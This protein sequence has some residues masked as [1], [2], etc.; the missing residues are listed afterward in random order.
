MTVSI[1]HLGCKG[2]FIGRQHCQWSRHTVV[3]D[4]FVISTLGMLQWPNREPDKFGDPPPAWATFGIEEGDYFESMVFRSAGTRT[5]EDGLDAGCG[6]HELGEELRTERYATAGEANAGH[7]A[8][9]EHYAGR[10]VV[11][12]KKR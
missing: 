9:V 2:H 8:L 12:R 4:I 6:C 11:Y 1:V 7:D 3:G 5:L 10:V